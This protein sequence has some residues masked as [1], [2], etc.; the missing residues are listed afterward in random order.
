MYQIIDPSTGILL[1]YEDNSS[2]NQISR[3]K[4]EMSEDKKKPNMSKNKCNFSGSGPEVHKE[5]T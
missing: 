4:L 3:A 2:G 5:T 1:S